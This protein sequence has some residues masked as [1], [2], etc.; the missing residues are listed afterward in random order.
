M[1]KYSC[2]L[3][4]YWVKRVIIESPYAGKDRQTIERNVYYAQTC[5]RHSVQQNEAPFASHLFYTQ[6]LHDTD[7]EERQ[8]GIR[9]GLCWGRYAHLAA[10]Y[11]DYGISSGMRQGIKEA[12]RRG[13]PIVYRSLKQGTYCLGHGWKKKIPTN[14]A[15][16]ESLRI[17]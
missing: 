3:P 16:E 5:C 10:V 12:L 8:L 15:F 1:D 14:R 4:T 7:S 11:V 17:A 6:F 2:Y 9:A 13:T